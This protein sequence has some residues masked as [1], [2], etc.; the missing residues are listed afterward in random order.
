MSDKIQFTE[1]QARRIY[2]AGCGLYTKAE[3][4]VFIKMLKIAGY[5]KKSKLEEAR[6]YAATIYK[7]CSD[8]NPDEVEELIEL[9]EAYISE[10][11]NE[12]R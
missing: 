11:E 5:I 10:I 8:W 4:Q 1:E 6:E 12:N 2:I 3:V 7:R 9:Y